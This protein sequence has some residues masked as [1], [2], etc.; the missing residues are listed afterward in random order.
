MG[1]FTIT[2][3]NISVVWIIE[4]IVGCYTVA[5][6]FCLTMI[7]I[8][9]ISNH[10]NYQK[11]SF[12]AKKLSA[13]AQWWLLGENL[14]RSQEQL[15][16]DIAQRCLCTQVPKN[17]TYLDLTLLYIL[18]SGTYGKF[19]R[20]HNFMFQH[21]CGFIS[22]RVGYLSNEADSQWKSA[23]KAS[24]GIRCWKWTNWSVAMQMWC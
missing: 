20:K 10:I 19:A 16:F 7:Y 24:H 4:N 6:M 12:L 23:H 9:S 1:N 3:N 8:N 11:A 15:E 22:G 5:S 17:L 18:I 14:F 21:Y 13:T 2:L